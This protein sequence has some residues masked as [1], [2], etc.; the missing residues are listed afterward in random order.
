MLRSPPLA[1]RCHH[2]E[3]IIGPVHATNQGASFRLKNSSQTESMQNVHDA[4]FEPFAQESSNSSGS[5]LLSAPNP[6]SG[7]LL[8]QRFEEG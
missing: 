1:S 6:H 2:S 3:R 7:I 4:L 5:L 8:L